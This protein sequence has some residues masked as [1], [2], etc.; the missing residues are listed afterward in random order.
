MAHSPPYVLVSSDSYPSCRAKDPAEAPETPRHLRARK[1]LARSKVAHGRAGPHW[2]SPRVPTS[3]HRTHVL[4][5]SCSQGSALCCRTYILRHFG[6]VFERKNFIEDIFYSNPVAHQ[7]P[8]MLGA[9]LRGSP[10]RS[11]NSGSL[12][13]PCPKLRAFP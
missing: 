12:G 9:C 4:P 3:G 8:P 6:D 11:L 7:A 5:G 10:R 1:S 13:L 2:A